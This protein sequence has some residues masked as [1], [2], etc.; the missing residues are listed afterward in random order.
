M[1]CT[2]CGKQVQ[3]GASNCTN[4]GSKVETLRIDKSKGEL[5]SRPVFNVKVKPTENGD[6]KG[7]CFAIGCLVAL[8]IF[9][10]FIV[11]NFFEIIELIVF[12]F[13]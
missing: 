12:M 4:C 1:F 5:P 10:I 11:P 6:S 7:G 2:Q 13:H 8:I 3:T 9:F